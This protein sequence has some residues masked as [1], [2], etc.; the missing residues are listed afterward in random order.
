MQKRGARTPQSK[1][2]ATKTNADRTRDLRDFCKKEFERFFGWS[3]MDSL[4]AALAL[5]VTSAAAREG[6]ELLCQFRK[7][8]E[9]LSKHA[10]DNAATPTIPVLAIRELAPALNVIADHWVLGE[11]WNAVTGKNRRV[12]RGDQERAWLVMVADGTPQ[13]LHGGL[14]F[15]PRADGSRTLLDSRELAAVSILA[16]RWPVPEKLPE[17]KFFEDE[18]VRMRKAIKNHGIK[19]DARGGPPLVRQPWDPPGTVIEGRDRRRTITI[20]TR[21]TD[22]QALEAFERIV[23]LKRRRAFLERRLLALGNSKKKDCPSQ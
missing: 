5:P 4:A 23:V 13:L 22:A 12:S 14:P 8:L 2:P 16:Y 11:A 17:K 10:A 6:R 9:A 18:V 21:R 3:W 1:A 15:P 19:N 7:S 20:T